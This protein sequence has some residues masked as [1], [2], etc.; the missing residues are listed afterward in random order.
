ME[1]KSLVTRYVNGR[2]E[3][4][5]G[6]PILCFDGRYLV[7]PSG[8]KTVTTV[9]RISGDL[10]ARNTNLGEWLKKFNPSYDYT[11]DITVAIVP[12][13][14]FKRFTLFPPCKKKEVVRSLAYHLAMSR[15]HISMSPEEMDSA[16]REFVS[17]LNG[18]DQIKYSSQI[19]AI[20]EMFNISKNSEN[21]QYM[22]TDL[23]LD[24]AAQFLAAISTDT[25]PCKI[26]DALE[27]SVRKTKKTM[28]REW[29]IHCKKS[30]KNARLGVHLQKEVF[31]M[32]EQIA[33]ETAETADINEDDID[34]QEADSV[35]N[36]EMGDEISET[37]NATG[38]DMEDDA[39]ED[40]VET[41]EETRRAI[42][43]LDRIDRM[44]DG[45]SAVEHASR[46]KKG[47]KGKKRKK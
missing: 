46:K 39:D 34:F 1:M 5:A 35:I 43:E 45:E 42:E 38:D 17:K 20:L 40:E 44:I 37:G 30:K 27:K 36:S 28:D 23:D 25:K 7:S 14:Y 16:V 15:L 32:T 26:R 11:Q 2:V 19:Y 12:L 8:I 4:L 10:A 18:D 41:D 29:K 3:S 22:V 47:K 31:E 6:M 13:W 9:A 33:S 21:D 24:M